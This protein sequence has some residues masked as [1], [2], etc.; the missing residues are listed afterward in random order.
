MISRWVYIAAGI[1]SVSLP[2]I[3]AAQDAGRQ[4]ALLERLAPKIERAQT[5]APDAHATISRL[6]QRVGLRTPSD[7][8]YDVRRQAAIDRVA[9]ALKV[10]Q[11]AD[12]NVSAR[13]GD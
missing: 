4:V 9:N 13:A 12:V 10:K 3:V 2:F 5:L 1:V 6:V 7:A 8:P 11:V